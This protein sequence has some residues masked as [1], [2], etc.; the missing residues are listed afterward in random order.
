MPDKC[1]DL[2]RLPNEAGES[3]ENDVEATGLACDVDPSGMTP[4][5][6]CGRWLAMHCLGF[7]ACWGWVHIAFFSTIFWE[8]TAE[9]LSM[10]AWLVNVFANGCA[11]VALGVFSAVRGPPKA[12][13]RTRYGI[14]ADYRL[15]NYRPRFCSNSARLLN[16][17][18][19]SDVG[20]WNGRTPSPL[21]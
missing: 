15:G 5:G 18:C 21:G 8:N 2:K 3:T 16:L 12:S 11:M 13:T 19:V 9:P 17:V 4:K 1:K 6:N 14:G 10:I 7:G 20:R